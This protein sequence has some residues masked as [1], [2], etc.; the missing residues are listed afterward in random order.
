MFLKE[1]DLVNFR[2]YRTIKVNFPCHKTIFIGKNAQGKTNI[3][4]AIYYLATLS[5]FRA[6]NDGELITWDEG[7]SRVHSNLVKNNT[8][9]TLDV[10]INP[11]KQK[12][13]KVNGLKKTSFSEFLGNLLVVNFGVSDLLL[14]RGSP[15]DRRRWLDDAISQLYPGYKDRL[16]KYNRIRTQ[17]NNLLKSFKG[18]INLSKTQDDSLSVWDESLSVTGSNL[19]HLRQKYLKEVQKIAKVKHSF[20]SYNE[21]TLQIEY[22]S[23]V[24]GNF[25]PELGDVLQPETIVDIFKET[26]KHRRAEEI[27]RAQTIVGPHRDDILFYINSIDAK[28][29]ASQGQQRTVVLSLKLAELEFIKSITGE[30]PILLLDDVLA[31]LDSTR[32]NFLL[33]SIPEDTQTII[34]TVDVSNFKEEYLKDVTVYNVSKGSIGDCNE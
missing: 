17:R 22:N 21:E 10:L 12:I 1:L 4:E 31:E 15:Q 14:L 16:L 28:S 26:L 11:P 2:N 20:I 13:L 27:V 25:N 34:T 3:L 30:T 7:Y 32:Q 29:F 9:V 5:S 8:N 18:N 23:T 6:S 33:N 24:S 19:I